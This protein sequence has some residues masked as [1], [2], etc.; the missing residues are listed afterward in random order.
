MNKLQE[1]FEEGED[2][3]V[4]LTETPIDFDINAIAGLLKL[5]LRKLEEK[6]IPGLI[7]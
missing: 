1:S 3:L 2:P 5:Y 7:D 4:E 6:L